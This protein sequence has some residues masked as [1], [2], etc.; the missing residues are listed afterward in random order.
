[1]RRV[2]RIRPEHAALLELVLPSDR[3][4]ERAHRFG[5]LV[6]LAC[7]AV[8]ELPEHARGGDG[9]VQVVVVVR[10]EA[11]HGLELR[12]LW[13]TGPVLLQEGACEARLEGVGIR[14]VALVVVVT[15]GVVGG[16]E[17]LAC[18]TWAVYLGRFRL[19]REEGRFSACMP[20]SVKIGLFSACMLASLKIS[21]SVPKM[22]F[23]GPLLKIE[24]MHVKVMR[25]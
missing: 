22:K 8:R 14:L 3:G 9:P 13:I 17:R 19:D 1:M 25:F 7:G 12:P 15:Y 4:R 2:E 24:N 6:L 21:S 18:V 23:S 16:S 20:A 11:L 10:E 5:S